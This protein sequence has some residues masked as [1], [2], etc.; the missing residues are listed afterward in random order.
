MSEALIQRLRD[1]L[2]GDALRLDDAARAQYGRDDSRRQG[3]PL[4][5][6][7]PRTADQVAA[8]VQACRDHRVALTTRGAGTGT[9]GAAVPDAGALV[10]SL[11]RMDRIV[12]IDPG[13]RLA[14]VEAG[15]INADLQRA[16]AAHGF[17]WP[18]DPASADRCTIGGNLACNAGGPRTVKYGAS[19]DNVL[20]VTAVDGHGRLFTSSR[21]L[22]K[23]ATG[24]NLTQ[25]LVGS[26]GTL[27]VIVDA[28]LRLHPLP[29]ASRALSA[30][31]RSVDAAALAVTRIMAQ[32]VTPSAVEFL[33]GKSLRLARAHAGD[34]VPDAG[35]LLLLE[36]DG[37]ADSLDAQ[38]ALLHDAVRVDGLIDFAV[39][40]DPAQREQVWAAR[41]ALSPA[42]R[43][44]A[45]KKINEDVVVPV[46]RLPAL[47]A[48]LDQLERDS[49]ILIVCFGHAGNGNLHVNLMLDPDDAAQAAAAPVALARLFDKVI[50]LCGALS[51]EHGIGLAKRPFMA[52]AVDPSALDLMR[53]LKTV[54][55]PDN[56]LNPGKVLPPADRQN[57]S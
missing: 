21:P 35:A 25:L 46:P 38:T 30:S 19:R 55:D 10:L 16:C 23:L 14:V 57:P 1:G 9:T 11:E 13:Q 49:D 27:A 29:E 15:V 41:R 22:S 40:T 6:A 43:S 51:G 34:A 44:L 3:A 24:Y 32:P 4:A 56:I 39:A 18:P 36:I 52:Q 42:L 37:S 31:F 17:F 7:L 5:V 2:P 20:S 26:E 33:D 28:T 8:I 53:G 48:F 50:E 47:I 12:D 54:F 45:P